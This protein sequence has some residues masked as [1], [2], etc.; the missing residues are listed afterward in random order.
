MTP[1]MKSFLIK[2]LTLTLILG[3]IFGGF[4]FFV[5][6]ESKVPSLDDAVTT[7]STELVR[8]VKIVAFGDS[9]TSGHRLPA[10]NSFPAELEKLLRA[11]GYNVVVKNYGE[12]GDTTTNGL[13][14]LPSVIEEAPDIVIVEFGAND[15]LKEHS[16][17]IARRNLLDIVRALKD[18]GI[19]VLLAGLEPP[20][21]LAASYAGQTVYDIGGNAIGTV[22]RNGV[23]RDAYGN[24]MGRVDR[25]GIA[26]SLDG[27]RRLGFAAGNI[28][29]EYQGVAVY[30]NSGRRIGTVSADG[31][32]RDASGQIVGRV[33]SDGRVVDGSGQIVGRA[34]RAI[35]EG[36]ASYVGQ[37]IYNDAGRLIGTV[38]AD[39]TVRDASGQIVGR[40]N[41]DGRVLDSTGR[42]IGRAERASS[43]AAAVY[44]GQKV[45]DNDGKLLGTVGAD[46]QV[47]DASGQIV[48]S[49]R[50]DGTVVDFG[51]RAIGK[52][53]STAA[54]LGQ[55]IY[56]DN[57]NVIGQRCHQL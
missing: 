10:A 31:I 22:D 37:K 1:L 33:D 21:H 48:G 42:A 51:G 49:V 27:S 41:P 55:K 52:T 57:G 14:R 50:D 3:L 5:N 9:L 4:L 2:K 26:Y 30:D 20:E 34:E 15:A 32:V 28:A 39:G 19:K 35:T 54:Y 47:R 8:Q 43:A 24:A 6:Y 36:S 56:D 44:A 53:I 25:N 23:I 45:F 38:S 11:K 13:R 12:S 18:V 7:D 46:G 40:V 17:E 16:M 29:A